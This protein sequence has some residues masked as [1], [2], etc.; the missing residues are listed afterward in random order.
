MVIDAGPAPE[1]VLGLLR[2]FGPDVT[3]FLDATEMGRLPGSICFLQPGETIELGVS[4]HTISPAMLA[5]FLEESIGCRVALVGIQPANN[6][7]GSPLS[8]FAEA[9]ADEV[10]AGLTDLLAEE[11]DLLPEAPHPTTKAVAPPP[12]FLR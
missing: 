10:L 8:P 4:T 7:F 9:A 2:R 11:P 6:A 3:L 5:E 1:N 12:P